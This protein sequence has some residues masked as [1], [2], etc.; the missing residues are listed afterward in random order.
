MSLEDFDQLSVKN[1]TVKYRNF[2]P[3]NGRNLYRYD[4]QL[5][6][7]GRHLFLKR[8]YGHP[9]ESQSACHCVGPGGI[10]YVAGHTMKD[11]EVTVV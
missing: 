7:L 8:R 6:R 4:N 9:L 11:L 3:A 10:L 1:L 5:I 2:L